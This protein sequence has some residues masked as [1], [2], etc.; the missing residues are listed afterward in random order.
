MQNLGLDVDAH[1][2]YIEAIVAKTW[3]E[4]SSRLIV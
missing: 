4:D 2:H 3:S 1:N